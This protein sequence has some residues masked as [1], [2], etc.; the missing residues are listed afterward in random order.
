MQRSATNI[1]WNATRVTW[2]GGLAFVLVLLGTLAGG[3]DARDAG[4]S[5]APVDIDNS[6]RIKRG[7]YLVTVGGCNDCHT[8]WK[9]GANGPEPDM[10]RMLSGHPET[11]AITA[12]AAAPEG[13]W[14][15][16]AVMGAT[17]TAF[18]GPWGVS[19]TANLTP[20][21][22]T[23]LGIWTEEMFIK[24][25]RTGRHWGVSRPIL[26]P[27]PWFNYRHMTDEDLRS[28]FAYLRSLPPVVNHVPNPIP[29]VA[30]T[31]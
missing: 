10:S 21:R 8:P 13:E 16:A 26:P 25:I 15:H 20:D 22:N 4:A 27:M 2:I 5:T 30:T 29:P 6:A 23:G 24:T 31:H 3:C 11:Y 19:F 7:A 1:T 18:S 14:Q 9:V 12:P 28:V 17:N